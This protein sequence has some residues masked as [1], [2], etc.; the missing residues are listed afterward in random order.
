MLDNIFVSLFT[1][2]MR[3]L[4]D[5]IGRQLRPWHYFKKIESNKRTKVAKNGLVT[6]SKEAE[7]LLDAYARNLVI[8]ISL[9]LV[10]IL[11]LAY[12]L[13]KVFF[14]DFGRDVNVNFYSTL[15]QI[16]PALLIALFLVGPVDLK[17]HSKE[18]LKRLQRSV[19]QR[20]TSGDRLFGILGFIVG[21]L[22]CLIA[23]GRDYS[24][25]GVYIFS[26]FGAGMLA[27]VLIQR[28]SN[29]L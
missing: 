2:H 13:E 23:I 29:R 21:E 11:L 17:L 4:L 28:I 5:K 14:P 18:H 27:T 3:T 12:G 19:W 10:L 22:A 15:A 16:L 7:K 9:L 1:N 26:L 20:L 25:T 24:G 6:F 8:T